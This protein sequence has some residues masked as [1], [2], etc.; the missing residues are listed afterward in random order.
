MPYVMQ[1]AL[2]NLVSTDF[3]RQLFYT[4]TTGLDMKFPAY[5]LCSVYATFLVRGTVSREHYTLC[6]ARSL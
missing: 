4:C 6:N 1:Y 5:I 3:L 2:S